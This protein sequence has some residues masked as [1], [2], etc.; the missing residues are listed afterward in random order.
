MIIER[1][2]EDPLSIL[3]KNSFSLLPVRRME[4]KIFSDMD[5]PFCS[6]LEV[7]RRNWWLYLNL[8]SQLYY[9]EILD[10]DQSEEIW[11]R[12]FIEKNDSTASLSVITKLFKNI[13]C[14][15][16]KTDIDEGEILEVLV[17]GVQNDGRAVFNTLKEENTFAREV[18]DFYNLSTESKEWQEG[19]YSV[20]TESSDQSLENSVINELISNPY[21]RAIDV[22]P[23]EAN[24]NKEN[25]LKYVLSRKNRLY[26]YVNKIPNSIYTK[27][28]IWL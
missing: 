13:E 8:A 25:L 16:A 19:L 2:K 7:V 6:M 3:K 22:T 10:L 24:T 27:T 9:Y 14:S 4:T 12:I 17:C 20:K 5:I 23:F 26:L 11:S 1:T 15:T 21:F 28:L 18:A